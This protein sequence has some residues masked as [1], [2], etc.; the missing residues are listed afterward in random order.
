MWRDYLD[1]TVDVYGHS[2]GSMDAQYALADLDPDD[3]GRI[4][5]AWMYEGPNIY[6]RLSGKQRKTVDKLNETGLVRNYVDRRDFGAYWV[7]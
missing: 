1:A 7:W 3:G 4:N 2:L 5:G 6:S